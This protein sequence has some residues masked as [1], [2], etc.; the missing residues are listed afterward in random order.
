MQSF[1][2]YDPRIDY[3]TIDHICRTLGV[4]KSTAYKIARCPASQGFQTGHKWFVPVEG[5]NNYM[6]TKQ[7]EYFAQKAAG[8]ASPSVKLAPDNDHSS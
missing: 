5:L 3:L 7:A 1:D 8:R 2:L 6:A 4:G